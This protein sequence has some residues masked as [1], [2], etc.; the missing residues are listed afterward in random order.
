MER[1]SILLAAWRLNRVFPLVIGGLLLLN[2]AVYLVI[3][4]STSPQLNALER[5]LIEQ[6]ASLREGRA[7]AAAQNPVK[8][9]RQG[10]SDL[11]K[12]AEAIPPKS[13]YTA[14]IGEIFS[15]AGRAGLA[16]DSIGYDPKEIA[17]QNLLR[18][19]LAFSVKG[20]YGQIKRFI[21]SL[22]QSERLIVIEDLALSGGGQPGEAQVEL[23]LR[24][25]TFFRTEAS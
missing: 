2:I 21:H 13:E 10:E 6:Q 16:I 3:S 22:E 7:G 8:A 9:Y 18:Y 25:A 11:N 14:L 23:R 19:G 20:D 15:L 24:L 5:Q 12:F 17:G 4:F 1:E